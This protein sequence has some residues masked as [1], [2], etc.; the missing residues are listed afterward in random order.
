MHL[1]QL[2]CWLEKDTLL[3]KK[4]KEAG[5]VS[6]PRHGRKICP[7]GKQRQGVTPNP[8]SSPISHSWTVECPYFFFIISILQMAYYLSKCLSKEAIWFLFPWS[9]VGDASEYRI[10]Q[11]NFGEQ[12]WPGG[13]TLRKP[14]HW[15][16]KRMKYPSQEWQICGLCVSRA[17]TR[18]QNPSQLRASAITK[19]LELA[20]D[21]NPCRQRWTYPSILSYNQCTYPK[22]LLPK[23][24]TERI[25]Y[26]IYLASTLLI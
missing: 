16:I 5:W 10:Q 26:T 4:R 7:P 9:V 23:P 14:R 13:L 3:R 1:N 20:Q 21:G 6:E 19:Y 11:D 8:A 24:N 2:G 17:W 25:R 12:M 15:W 18:P 22:P